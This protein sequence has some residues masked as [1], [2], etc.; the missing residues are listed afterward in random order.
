MKKNISDESLTRWLSGQ[1]SPEEETEVLDYLSESDEHIDDLI[2]MVA[3]TQV[4]YDMQHPRK[5]VY[6]SSKKNII[7]ISLSIAAS[8]AL[9]IC[10]T[11]PLWRTDSPQ[12]SLT[13][14]E[15]TLHTEEAPLYA[16]C[17]TINDE[18]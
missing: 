5:K 16:T 14:T 7:K 13:A 18:N 9:L 4:G 10:L 15:H 8:I 2:M 3:A 1:A 6:T 17:D 11:I 12:P